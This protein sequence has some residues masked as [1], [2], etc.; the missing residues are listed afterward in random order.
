MNRNGFN[1]LTFESK[2]G[3]VVTDETTARQIAEA[4]NAA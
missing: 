4:W 3:A 2:H 1:C